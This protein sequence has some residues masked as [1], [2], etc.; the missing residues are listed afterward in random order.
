M[1]GFSATG[2]KLE[3]IE[4]LKAVGMP[5]YDRFCDD[6]R[7]FVLSQ[8]EQMTYNAP[9]GWVLT[10]RID[11]EGSPQSS[12]RVTIRSQLVPDVENVVAK[13]PGE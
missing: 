10:Y 6:T 8:L 2:S 7:M 9:P 1:F 4:Q 11:A 13:A 5:A 12:L 3:V